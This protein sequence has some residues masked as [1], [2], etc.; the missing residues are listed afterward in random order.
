MNWYPVKPTSGGQA[1]R[2]FYRRLMA[3]PHWV[4]EAKLD[5]W[6]VVW[7]GQRLWTRTGKPVGRRGWH[8]EDALAGCTRMM[9]GELY[10]G[11]LFVFDLPACGGW[12]DDRR[13]ELCNAVRDIE[14][15]H[16]M[17]LAQD[18]GEVERNEWEG[19]VLKFKSSRYPRGH[20]VGQTTPHWLKYRAAWG[21]K[22]DL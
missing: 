10:Q 11:K 9:D 17:P 14:G 12:W 2:P 19:L 3:S 20:R 6:R 18:W 13:R 15:V 4:A 7:C 1:G 22:G 5:G 8:L 21:F 16:P